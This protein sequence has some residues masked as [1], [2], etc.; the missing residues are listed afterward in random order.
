MYEMEK[1]GT[2]SAWASHKRGDA[3]SSEL[4]IKDSDRYNNVAAF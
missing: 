2:Q 4:N 1:R 3:W